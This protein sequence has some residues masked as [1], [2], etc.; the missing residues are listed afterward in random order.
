MVFNILFSNTDDYA[1]FRNGKEM[2][3]TLACGILPQLRM[4]GEASH[5]LM[6]PMDKGKLHY[7]LD[8]ILGAE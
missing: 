2:A 8:T 1:A 6:S 7:A 4:G 3:L 5:F